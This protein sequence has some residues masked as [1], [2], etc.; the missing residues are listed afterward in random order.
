[1]KTI[2]FVCSLLAASSAFAN[3]KHYAPPR[4]DDRALSA[5]SAMAPLHALHSGSECGVDR[6][7]PLFAESGGLLGYECSSSANGS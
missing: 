6:A 3:S 5:N 7:S 1:M 4:V 2:L